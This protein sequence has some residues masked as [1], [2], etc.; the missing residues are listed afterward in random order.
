M[1]FRLNNIAG[2]FS[3][4]YPL[5]PW[6]FKSDKYNTGSFALMMRLPTEKS[7]FVGLKFDVYTDK[8]ILDTKNRFPSF[9][10]TKAALAVLQ[11]GQIGAMGPQRRE[12]IATTKNHKRIMQYRVGDST[13]NRSQIS[14]IGGINTKDGWS[15]DL[16]LNINE[17][18]I[19]GADVPQAFFFHDPMNV[20]RFGYKPQTSYSLSA[21]IKYSGQ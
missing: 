15:A 11:N 3:D 2:S 14:L 18:R 19:N 4:E 6:N 13:M 5:A 16:S 10:D 12:A 9:S 17:W 1:A 21:A 20:P 8:Q 7:S